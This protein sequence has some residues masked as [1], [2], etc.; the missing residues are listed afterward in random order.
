MTKLL[1]TTTTITIY[2]WYDDNSGSGDDHAVTML[3]DQCGY[4][5]NE[6]DDDDDSVK[7]ITDRICAAC[8][9]HP[10]GLRFE[11]PRRPSRATGMTVCAVSGCCRIGLWEGLRLGCPVCTATAFSTASV[12]EGSSVNYCV[13]WSQLRV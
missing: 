12:F 7:Q 8:R 13:V 6:D 9:T 11:G 2:N 3:A 5:A 4:H 1:R 10:D